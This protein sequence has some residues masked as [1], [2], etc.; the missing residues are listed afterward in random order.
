MQG[1]SCRLCKAST[2]NRKNDVEGQG[3]ENAIFAPSRGL[4]K[5]RRKPGAV[6]AISDADN[7]RVGIGHDGWEAYRH[8]RGM[9]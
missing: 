6:P 8:L 4:H 9:E 2:L 5:K 3:G 1:S 7:H